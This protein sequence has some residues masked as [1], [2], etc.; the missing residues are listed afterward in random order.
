MLRG[1]LEEIRIAQDA[2]LFHGPV[3]LGT[4]GFLAAIESFSYLVHPQA[5]HIQPHHLRLA[6]A[7][8]GRC[9]CAGPLRLTCLQHSGNRWGVVLAPCVRSMNGRNQVRHC[10]GLADNRTDPNVI[11]RT[12]DGRTVEHRQHNKL[13]LRKA[14]AN[15]AEQRDAIAVLARRH[16]VVG[17]QHIARRRLEQLDEI[18]RVGGMPFQHDGVHRRQLMRYPGNHPRMVVRQHHAN[19]EAAH[20]FPPFA[21]CGS[22]RPQQT[23]Q[24]YDEG[25]STALIRAS[26]NTRSGSPSRQGFLCQLYQPIEPGLQRLQ[27]I[28]SLGL[29]LHFRAGIR[30]GLLV[31]HRKRTAHGVQMAQRGFPIVGRQCNV[32]GFQQLMR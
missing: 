26:H 32:Q 12:E 23:I 7:Q 5:G 24:F 13:H 29:L 30:N 28:A 14:P 16:G 15:E 18:G 27:I 21:D 17:H 6:R 25:R 20:S 4:D 1:V 9:R 19:A 2:E 22:V 10:V 11:E 8:F 3:L 31:H